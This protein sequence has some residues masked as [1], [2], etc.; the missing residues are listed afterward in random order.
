MNS[1]NVAA[2]IPTEDGSRS[3]FVSR[4]IALPLIEGLNARMV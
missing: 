4:A 3:P 1:L 2:Y